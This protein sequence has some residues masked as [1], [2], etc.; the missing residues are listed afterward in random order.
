MRV[1]KRLFWYF[2]GHLPR[3]A[4]A[5]MTAQPEQL[6]Q[7][8]TDTE[9]A[10]WEGPYRG[11]CTCTHTTWIPTVVR[12]NIY[13]P[14]SSSTLQEREEKDSR[15]VREL[16]LDRRGSDFPYQIREVGGRWGKV[17]CG[18]V[19]GG[20]GSEEKGGEQS[21]WGSKSPKWHEANVKFLNELDV[22]VL[23][24]RSQK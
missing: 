23:L 14:R 8:T 18:G 20:G 21:C 1:K 2:G 7:Q 24:I 10:C 17:I 15:S 16:E 12:V 3:R 6:L 11:A 13:R 22:G 9:L 4:V 19:C 5:A